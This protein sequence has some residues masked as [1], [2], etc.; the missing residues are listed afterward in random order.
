MFGY[1]LVCR[2]YTFVSTVHHLIIIIVQTYPKALNLKNSCQM[3]FVECVTT[4]KHIL[5]VTYDTIYGAVCFQ[6]THF[7][8]YDG[9]NIYTLSYYHHQI[10]SMNN[11]PLFRV[12]S[13][14]NGVRCMPFCILM[15]YI[16]LI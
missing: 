4:I 8:C 11:C 13:R 6:C 16:G 1:V 12:R 10:A 2:S 3:Y 15:H 7:T 5:S 9:D 14:N